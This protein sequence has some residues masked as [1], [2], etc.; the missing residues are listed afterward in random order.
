[1]LGSTRPSYPPHGPCSRITQDPYSLM[2]ESCKNFIVSLHWWLRVPIGKKCRALASEL[3]QYILHPPTLKPWV[4]IL[5]ASPCSL[6]LLAYMG[7]NPLR[8]CWTI[9]CI[10]TCSPVYFYPEDED[11]MYLLNICNTL[12]KSKSRSNFNKGTVKPVLNRISRVHNIKV[13]RS[14]NISVWDKIPFNKG[15]V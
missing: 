2:C 3:R 7:T 5:T 8:F 15:S 14:E 10:N 12:W 9:T 13:T 1:M 6:S 4:D 11:S